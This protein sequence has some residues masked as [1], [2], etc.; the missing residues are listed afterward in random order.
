MKLW[1][2][3]YEEVLAEVDSIQSVLQGPSVLVCVGREPFHPHLLDSFQKNSEDKLPK[4][5]LK[6]QS[7]TCNEDQGYKK[8]VN[9]GLKSKKRV[10]SGPFPKA[11][12]NILDDDIEKR[13][14]VNKDGSLSMEMKVR[15]RLLNEETLHCSTEIKK[16]SCTFNVSFPGQDNVISPQCGHGESCSEAESLSAS[17]ADDVYITK[18]YQKHLE[19]PHCKHCCTHCQEYNIWKNPALLS[20][21]ETLRHYE[22]TSSS[23]LSHRIKS[24]KESVDSVHTTS[25]E[26]YTE[27]VVEKAT[28]I[29]Q[30]VGEGDKGDSTVQYC[31][32]SRCCSRSEV[33]SVS[34]KAKKA[35]YTDEKY[36]KNESSH[37]YTEEEKRPVSS[38]NLKQDQRVQ[39]TQVSIEDERPLSVETNSSDILASLKDDEDREETDLSPSNSRASQSNKENEEQTRNAVVSPYSF[40]PCKPPESPKQSL[41]TRT[42]NTASCCSEKTSRKVVITETQENVD[43][44]KNNTPSSTPHRCQHKESTDETTENSTLD[45]KSEAINQPEDVLNK[46]DVL[47]TETDTRALKSVSDLSKPCD[48]ISDDTVETFQTNEKGRSSAM[49]TSPIPQA[50]LTIS[51]TLVVAEQE[52]VNVKDPIVAYASEEENIEATSHAM[53]ADSDTSESPVGKNKTEEPADVINEENVASAMSPK[54][55]VSARSSQSRL[56]EVS[57]KERKKAELQKGERAKSVLSVHSNAS[58]ISMQ[59]TVSELLANGSE[60]QTDVGKSELREMEDQIEDRSP[61]IMSVKSSISEAT[62][63]KLVK[64][65]SAESLT[66][67][68]STKTNISIQSMASKISEGTPLDMDKRLLME[69]VPSAMSAKSD[70][71]VRSKTS[72]ILDISPYDSDV[73]EEAIE[74]CAP[75]A[76]SNKSNT[77]SRSNTPNISTVATKEADGIEEERL[78]RP[79]SVMSSKSAASVRSTKSKLRDEK[80][81]NT[82]EKT[83]QLQDRYI[84]SVMP[85]KPSDSEL[86]KK[87]KSSKAT[88]DK[89]GDFEDQSEEQAPSTMSTK[90]NTPTKS[91]KSEI[92]ETCVGEKEE[93]PLSTMSSISSV[94]KKSEKCKISEAARECDH[95]EER[96]ASIMSSTSVKS[97]KSVVSDAPCENE[98]EETK[99]TGRR[100]Q[101]A[102]SVRSQRSRQSKASEAPRQDNG[103]EDNREGAPSAMSCKSILSDSSNLAPDGIDNTGSTEDLLKE[104][105]SAYQET[106]DDRAASAMSHKSQMS[107]LSNKSKDQTQE[108]ALTSMSAKS[109]VSR[110]SKNS[111]MDQSKDEGEEKHERAS[112]LVSPNSNMSARS[113]KPES[114]EVVSPAEVENHSTERTLSSMSGNSNTSKTSKKN[115]V[116]DCFKEPKKA[117]KEGLVERSPSAVSAKSN[118]SVRSKGSD[119]Q[120]NIPMEK[121]CLH[122]ISPKSSTSIK[123][124]KSNFRIISNNSLNDDAVKS[125]ETCDIKIE[126]RSPSDM[127]SKSSVS[128]ISV[129]SSISALAGGQTDIVSLNERSDS[130]LSGLKIP[131]TEIPNN[132]DNEERAS[133]ALSKKS[134]TSSVHHTSERVLTPASPSVSIGIVEEYDV[135]NAEED[136]SVSLASVNSTPQLNSKTDVCCKDAPKMTEE[137]NQQCMQTPDDRAK[138]SLTAGTIVSDE[139][140]KS[141]CTHKNS[142]QPI[143]D[144]EVANNKSAKKNSKKSS[145]HSLSNR[146]AHSD[147]GSSKTKDRNSP[148][149]TDRPK[150]NM[151]NTLSHLEI[152]E[153]K[154]YV[155]VTKC[156]SVGERS[157]SNLCDRYS[158]K[159]KEI[160]RPHSADMLITSVSTASSL[161]RQKDKEP[162]ISLGVSNHRSSPSN[163]NSNKLNTPR[164]LNVCGRTCN[165]SLVA[166]DCSRNLNDNKSEK[167]S[168]SS[169]RHSSSSL[170]QNIDNNPSELV[171]SILPSSSPTEVVNEWLKKIPLDSALYD[172]GDEF[173]ENCEEEELSKMSGK[174]TQYERGNGSEGDADAD[175]LRPQN[176]QLE[177]EEIENNESKVFDM[178]ETAKDLAVVENIQ[179]CTFPDIPS[180]VQLMRILLSPKLG[181]C[182]SL[183]EI[184]TVYGRKLST[185]ARGFLESLVNLQLLDFDPNDINGK[186]EKYKDLMNMLQSLWLCDPSDRVTITQKSK[187]NNQQSKD[188]EFNVKS[189]SGVD[190]NSSSQDSGKSS[191]NE[192]TVA[193]KSQTEGEDIGI[194]TKAHEIDKTEKASK[195]IETKSDS[196]TPDIASRVRWTPENE[197]EENMQDSNILSAV[198][199]FTTR[200]NYS[201]REPP[202][203][204]SHKSSG[205][206][207]NANEKLT[208]HEE[209]TSSESSSSEQM[210]QVTKKVSQDP[211]PVWVLNLLNKI[212]KQF[213]THYVTAMGEF[214]VRWN[215]NDNEQLDVM[216]CELRDEVHK[217]IQASINNELRK[218]QGHAGRPRP[219]KESLSRE[220]RI[221]TEQR[222]RRLKINLN[223]SIDRAEKTDDDNT[224]ILMPDFNDQRKDDEYCP[225]D[226]C[227]KKKTSSR[228]GLAMEVST[229]APMGIDFDLRKILHLKRKAPSNSKENVKETENE[230]QHIEVGNLAESEADTSNDKAFGKEYSQAVVGSKPQGIRKGSS[231]SLEEDDTQSNKSEQLK[232]DQPVKEGNNTSRTLKQES[233]IAGGELRDHVELRNGTEILEM[234]N[235]DPTA[236]DENAQSG[237]ADMGTEAKITADEEEFCDELAEDKGSLEGETV[238]KEH[239]T[240]AGTAK[241]NIAIEAGTVGEKEVAEGESTEGKGTEVETSDA[242][243]GDET[244]EESMGERTCENN[245]AAE[246]EISE[247][248]PEEGGKIPDDEKE[249]HED[250]KTETT[251]KNMPAKPDITAEAESTKGEAAEKEIATTATEEPKIKSEII[252]DE[253]EVEHKSDGIMYLEDGTDEEDDIVEAEKSESTDNEERD[254][255]ESAEEDVAIKKISK[256]SGEDYLFD[257]EKTS[258]LAEDGAITDRES[259]EGANPIND[260]SAK[261][262]ET[263]SDEVDAE[264]KTTKAETAAD[265]EP[266]DNETA[267]YREK[268]YD[269]TSDRTEIIKVNTAEIGETNNNVPTD[270]GE[271]TGV[272]VADV[273]EIGEAKAAEDDDYESA[274]DAETSKPS[275]A[276]DTSDDETAEYGETPK[277]KITEDGEI[278]ND[279]IADDEGAVTGKVKIAEDKDTDNDEISEIEEMPCNEAADSGITTKAKTTE[280]EET[281]DDGTSEDGEAAGAVVVDDEESDASAEEGGNNDDDDD[282]ER[283][284]EPE[285]AKTEVSEIVEDGEAH[286]TKDL[287]QFVGD[288]M[289]VENVRKTEDEQTDDGE[290]A[291][292]RAHDEEDTEMDTSQSEEE[293][294]TANDEADNGERAD[295]GTAEESG[296]NDDDERVEEPERAKTEVSE[297][298]VDSDIV[299]DGEEHKTK[300]LKQFV[301]D[302]MNIEN[303]Q[304][305]E[306]EQTDDGETADG[307]AHDEEDTEMDTSQS[308]KEG[309]T[310]DDEADNGEITD[311]GTAEDGET[312]NDNTADDGTAEDEK[313]AESDMEEVGETTEPETAE[314]GEQEDNGRADGPIGDDEV[315]DDDATTGTENEENEETVEV[316]TVEDGETA[317]NGTTE[318]GDTA[319]ERKAE[320][321]ELSEDEIAQ[322]EEIAKETLEEYGQTDDSES[323]ENGETAGE[324]NGET[325][326]SNTAEALINTHNI[327]TKQNSEMMSINKD[328]GTSES[329]R[330]NVN[331][332]FINTG[333]S[334]EGGDEAEDETEPVVEID[335]RAQG[336]KVAAT[337]PTKWSLHKEDQ[338][339]ERTIASFDSTVKVYTGSEDEADAD[340]EDSETEVHKKDC[341]VENEEED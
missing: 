36:G 22:S 100:S 173:H 162:V 221:L 208:E 26:E 289:N 132:A 96:P 155:N 258:E 306:D 209:D 6:S 195:S 340:G 106:K 211:D 151:S 168:N 241:E 288:K 143:P 272:K 232:N 322:N 181:R 114:L 121:I 267:E 312:P 153:Q 51:K 338:A 297:E 247:S 235:A 1:P 56:S 49:S 196:A 107:S 110:K 89:S 328:T 187:F 78:K 119:T 25:C 156:N 228:P 193:Q 136:N 129:K 94:S 157:K 142:S 163:E 80:D 108:R 308:E 333:E 27:Q 197:A 133:S 200:K 260:E 237:P 87:S 135:D 188:E 261:E 165:G 40:T 262:G 126:E 8:N 69:R 146:S 319:D 15:F 225:C 68:V 112:I 227:M 20:E 304:K 92:L 63:V 291:D 169:C 154:S 320:D 2:E 111:K 182:N 164:D 205:N 23:A 179:P 246:R 337:Q 240:E 138:S 18:R 331:T 294:E 167:N 224:T 313:P 190:I 310:A 99:Q 116:L 161:L 336:I 101:N 97:K 323:L 251:G 81:D 93:R 84:T 332:H 127:S 230:E 281:H 245:E 321:E 44:D 34:A 263:D 212:E 4:L 102:L 50:E 60:D 339:D 134:N 39:N 170:A 47:D 186:A 103:N 207:S 32:I 30:S 242:E 145:S 214:K 77:S 75:S 149:V 180:S 234:V 329:N 88:V 118:T 284:E 139:S 45:E 325:H 172:V 255:N 90:S 123:D 12:E 41:S 314:D 271:T 341:R 253:K 158:K 254:A 300:A 285:R 301:G 277:A 124:E 184:S 65:Q 35:G 298:K 269:D 334:D 191:V 303:V 109:N 55:D 268:F 185:S 7:S 218:I 79:S 85:S 233:P 259:A 183:P 307:R 137:E 326:G 140:K 239:A 122:T 305:T 174:V 54:S 226:T 335:G 147:F 194:L 278:S 317:D 83:E 290:T 82:A 295:D 202:D 37:A 72:N 279:G 28:C 66:S 229:S 33:C 16:S 189:S 203:T 199:D 43:Q 210:A 150:N 52:F 236:E 280:Y 275:T 14:L 231:S 17:E 330:Y 216:I 46:N 276:E 256:E 257:E 98:E 113:K 282:D 283:A 141:E 204:A 104:T 125:K 249:K 42:S 264:G 5:I 222:H 178:K 219:P 192:R 13:V 198:S 311:D 31:T 287:N 265:E 71:S 201:P 58:T 175:V 10:P 95:L 74:D 48:D 206:D 159:E 29:Q 266:A 61:S 318:D 171:P 53:S 57:C 217:R 76:K 327:K 293:G 86:S 223:Q 70:V 244:A 270:G 130:A 128:S 166:T 286:K 3:V 213:M 9:F 296:N 117:N 38:K 160:S 11:R 274:E 73:V 273:G 144:N 324:V 64:V 215:L 252:E 316:K 292:G 148:T 176:E 220:S 115:T 24:K 177:V 120:S 309:E 315:T 243:T 152:N 248:E 238:R 302:K 21:H 131:M 250:A 59:S 105:E 19:E 67:A 91:N 62:H 299:E